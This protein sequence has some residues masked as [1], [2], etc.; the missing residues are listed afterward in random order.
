MLKS[1][2][3]KKDTPQRMARKHIRR[4]VFLHNQKMKKLQRKAA[5]LARKTAETSFEA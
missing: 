5:R 4:E 2:P 3:T 1:Y